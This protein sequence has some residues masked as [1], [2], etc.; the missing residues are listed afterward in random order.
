MPRKKLSI[1]EMNG[2]VETLDVEAPQSELEHLHALYAE[3][4]ALGINSIGDLE[5]KIA[6]LQ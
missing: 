5:V 3:L 6:R 2:E 4:K 1:E